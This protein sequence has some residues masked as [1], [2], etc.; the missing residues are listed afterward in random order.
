MGII[1]N[2]NLQKKGNL[3]YI[4]IEVPP[5]PI[6]ISCK[7]SYY[8]RSST[9]QRLTGPELE[10]FI[11]RRR[12]ITWDHAPLP[13]F[14]MNDVDDDVIKRF[15]APAAKKGRIELRKIALLA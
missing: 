15:K 11:L 9:N 10:S 6:A 2:V 8:Y 1:I 5:Y 3:E 13:H 4:E 14:T 7:G 12:S